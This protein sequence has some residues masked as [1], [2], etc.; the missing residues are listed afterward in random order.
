MDC[1]NKEKLIESFYNNITIRSCFK[2]NDII[3]KGILEV[4]VKK[5]IKSNSISLNFSQFLGN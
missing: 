2:I 1:N 4:L 5:F 3:Y